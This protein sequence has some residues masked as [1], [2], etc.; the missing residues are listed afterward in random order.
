MHIPK[1]ILLIKQYTSGNQYFVGGTRNPYKGDFF[2]VNGN[3]Y[4]GKEP[5]KDSKPLENIKD[6][7]LKDALKIA[8]NAIKKHVFHPSTSSVSDHQ[9]TRYFVKKTNE[10]PI[11]ITE[12]DKNTFALFQKEPGYQTLALPWNL[13]DSNIDQVNQADKTFSGIKLFLQDEM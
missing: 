7:L 11:K 5:T 10:T 6:A 8:K 9:T 12:V 13:I 4:T 1:N 2:V 3:A